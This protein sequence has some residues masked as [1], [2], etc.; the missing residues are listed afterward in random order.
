MKRLLA[1]LAIFF[2]ISSGAQAQIKAA[3]ETP[4][5]ITGLT[6]GNEVS[7]FNDQHEN[8][9][10][11]AGNLIYTDILQSSVDENSIPDKFKNALL[12]RTKYADRGTMGSG[13]V[14][15]LTTSEAAQVCFW[16]SIDIVTP[17]TWLA[18]DGFVLDDTS[19]VTSVLFGGFHP[20]CQDLAAS[21]VLGKGNT[22]DG[23]DGLPMYFITV[24]AAWNAAP[25][26]APPSGAGD[27]SFAFTAQTIA[28]STTENLACVSRTN[29]N[30]GAVSV[31]I[32]SDT[33]D[34]CAAPDSTY[35]DPTTINW[36]TGIEGQGGCL[37]F[38]ANAVGA[39]CTE[40]L[41][42]NNATGGISAGTNTTTTIT[43]EDTPAAGSDYWVG[44]AGSD[45]N[46]CTTAQTEGT[47]KLTIAAGISCVGSGE[48]LTVKAGTYVESLTADIAGGTSWANL[49][50][51]KVKSG[52][53]VII[54]PT[55]SNRCFHLNGNT[56]KYINI[57]GFYCDGQSRTVHNCIKTNDANHIRIS[58]FT[59]DSS[60]ASGFLFAQTGTNTC[61]DIE[62]L[63]SIAFGTNQNFQHGVYMQCPNA[64]IWNNLFYEVTG[65][66]IQLYFG[67]NR[68]NDADIQYNTCFEAGFQGNG[69][70]NGFGSCIIISGHR[71][72]VANNIGYSNNEHHIVV[73]HGDDNLIYNNTA[74]NNGLAGIAV[75][76]S[77]A[78]GTII[79]NNII[80]ANGS[81]ISD[82]GTG[83]ITGNNVTSDPSFTDAANADFTFGSGSSACEAGE[84]LAIVTD[85]FVGT[86]RPQDT[87][88]E[89]GAYEIAACP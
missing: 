13:T 37:S 77:D 42:L 38:Q 50:T 35:T 45:A 34:T 64:K 87:L 74:Y 54:K 51:I 36:A 39:D 83:T 2:V 24:G 1:A 9:L 68:V 57:D 10:P 18:S 73:T 72:L 67:T 25:V 61:T 31:D 14:V 84:T 44:K 21:T 69:S 55:G 63:D 88:Y 58:N 32:A 23:D 41:Q 60:F 43:I 3:G 86:S 80:F 65:F 8:T 47:P 6:A 59:C 17:S 66:G 70:G 22:T 82:N 15:S 56:N 53:T 52:D 78:V 4:I 40:N 16:Y 11:K 89:A 5:D 79:K 19:L 12:I 30:S 85:D 28:E 29:G 7:T 48:T 27:Y 46:S 20:Y 81:T 62:V 33:G 26:V 49:T 76:Y 71:N 75:K